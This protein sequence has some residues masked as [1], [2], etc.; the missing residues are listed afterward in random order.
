[1]K[2]LVNKSTWVTLISLMILSVSSLPIQAQFGGS[3]LVPASG[4]PIEELGL[5][6][7]QDFA[8]LV[9]KVQQLDK[10]VELVG[11]FMLD[12]KKSPLADMQNSQVSVFRLKYLPANSAAGTISALLGEEGFRMAIEEKSNQLLVSAPAEIS[13]A[14]GELLQKIDAAPAQK[15]ENRVTS[16]QQSASKNLQVHLFLARRQEVV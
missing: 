1:M 8:K 11:K 7:E 6:L 4:L 2:R 13:E 5:K 14:I 16:Q 12:L 3:G 15:S 9:K 10:K